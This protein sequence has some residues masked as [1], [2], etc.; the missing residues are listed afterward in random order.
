MTIRWTPSAL[1]DVERIYAFVATVDPARGRAIVEAL[2]NRVERLTQLPGIGQRVPRYEPREVRR[3]FIG[4]YEL[5]YEL[6]PS[7]I[8]VLRVWHT[9]E[10][11]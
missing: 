8:I 2:V 11:R 3:L 6:K 4:D 7:T 10:D 1:T 5:R 9:R